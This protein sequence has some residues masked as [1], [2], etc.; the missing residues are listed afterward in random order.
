ME[1]IFGGCVELFGENI[2]CWQ[3]NVEAAICFYTGKVI[4][5]HR[6]YHHIFPKCIIEESTSSHISPT[7]T[8]TD[9][10]ISGEQ[11]SSVK[12]YF[13]FFL[14]PVVV[15]SILFSSSVSLSTKFESPTVIMSSS[16][17]FMTTE[18]IATSGNHPIAY[19][20]MKQFIS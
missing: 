9:V 20:Y 1:C 2:N 6:I 12:L 15:N 13:D 8:T 14:I 3:P 4:I 11:V 17:I 18:S 10:D 5:Y 19:T 16:L 7:S